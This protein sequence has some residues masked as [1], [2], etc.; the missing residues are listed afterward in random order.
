MSLVIDRFHPFGT[1][2]CID[3]RRAE[4]GVPEQLLNTAEVGSGIQQMSGE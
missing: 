2:V 4:I 1:D 3:L